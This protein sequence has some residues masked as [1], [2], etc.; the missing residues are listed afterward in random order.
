M[1]LRAA[2]SVLAI[3]TALTACSSSSSGGGPASVANGGSTGGGAPVTAPASGGS[4]GDFCANL[5]SAQGK[6]SGLGATGSA[7]DYNALAAAIGQD[8]TVFQ[9]LA[10]GAPADVK[11]AI[12]DIVTSLQSAQSA[13]ADP[14]HPDVAKLSGLATKLPTDL[15]AL[16]TYLASNCK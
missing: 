10:N 5:T 8:I 9:G 7:G 3:A 2:V 1:K 14:T 15:T 12:D 11:P 6:L 13:V 16:A 4:S